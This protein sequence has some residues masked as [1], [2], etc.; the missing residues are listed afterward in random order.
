M[1]Q[2][3]NQTDSIN[4]NSGIKSICI[5]NKIQVLNVSKST[6]FFSKKI[7]LKKI[8]E[9]RGIKGRYKHKNVQSYPG[10]VDM[11]LGP[12]ALWEPQ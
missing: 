7:F 8:T 6:K 5:K 10:Q 12:K 2:I 9:F 4:P 1:G 11:W 3:S